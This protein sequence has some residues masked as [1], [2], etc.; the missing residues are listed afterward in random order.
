VRAASRADEAWGFGIEEGT[1]R[2]FLAKYGLHLKDHMNATDIE[3]C[4][5]R[6]VDGKLI[7]RVSGIHCLAT[8]E[9]E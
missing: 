8:A 2:D 7:G 9:K 1:I 6:R 3:N 5:F 4:Y